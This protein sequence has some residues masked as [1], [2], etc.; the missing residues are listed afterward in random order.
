MVTKK[1]VSNLDD[2]VRQML[3][4]AGNTSV[5]NIVY[6]FGMTGSS[7]ILKLKIHRLTMEFVEAIKI[8]DNNKILLLADNLEGLVLSQQ[9]FGQIT[10][11]QSE[12]LINK[13][14]SLV[15]MYVKD[16]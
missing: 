6:S 9:S 15:K 10:A 5:N 14:H 16:K 1:S 11:K 7:D 2:F 4:V 3:Y 12:D 8:L 13:L